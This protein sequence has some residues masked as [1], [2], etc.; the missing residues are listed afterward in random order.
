VR[1]HE[2]IRLGRQGGGELIDEA[3]LS[4][5]LEECEQ[6]NEGAPI[7]FFEIT[8]AAAFLAYARNPADYLVMEVGLGGRLDATNVVDDPALAVITTVDYDHQQYLGDTLT[9][10]AGEKAGILK[11]GVPGVVAPQPDEALAAIEERAEEIGSPLLVARRD[12]QAFEQQGRLVYEDEDALFDLPLPGLT[13]RFQIDNA[14]TAIAAIRSLRDRRIGE[15]AIRQGLRRVEWRARLQ[16]L[17]P[18]RLHALVP[19]DVELWLDGGHNPSA[20]R[21]L[22]ASLAEFGE[23]VPRPLVLVVGMLNSKEARG[24]MR[25]F[26]DLARRIIAVT[27]PGEENALPADQL[28]EMA[29]SEGIDADTAGSIEEA[30]AAAGQDGGVRVLIT[31]SLYLAGRV[32]AL[33]WGE[34]RSDITGTSRR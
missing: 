28:A 4:A 2:R 17:A 10:I 19:Q 9:A 14:G 32:L 26:R 13:G 15:D 16:L 25:P 3:E 30:V 20:G 21:A 27:I 31:G 24:F 22:A 29:R 6:A 18:G 11:P 1:F 5:L 8:T 33:Q 23:R 7:T 34:T 12:W